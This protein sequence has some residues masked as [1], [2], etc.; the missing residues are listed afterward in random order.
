[1]QSGRS[2]WLDLL[3][4]RCRGRRRR[5]D[6]EMRPAR[7]AAGGSGAARIA[8]EPVPERLAGDPL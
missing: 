5:L 8:R 2:V 3:G 6:G 7:Q 4:G 1:V